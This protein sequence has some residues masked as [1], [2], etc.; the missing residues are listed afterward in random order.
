MKILY[1]LNNKKAYYEIDK[2]I[3]F[4]YHTTSGI[5]VDSIVVK[6]PKTPIQNI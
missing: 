2:S 5:S 3:H 4:L 1:R 6:Y